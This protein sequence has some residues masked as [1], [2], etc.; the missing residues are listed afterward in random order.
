[1]KTQFDVIRYIEE[2][3]KESVEGMSCLNHKIVLRTNN[4]TE[5]IDGNH[6]VVEEIHIG[7]AQEG[8]ERNSISVQYAWSVFSEAGNQMDLSEEEKEQVNSFIEYALQ[9]LITVAVENKINN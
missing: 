4:L 2:E 1:M 3:P 6:I 5:R 7:T 9:N 8:R